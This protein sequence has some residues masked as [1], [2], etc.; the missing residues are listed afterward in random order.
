MLLVKSVTN[1]IFFS[2]IS[3]KINKLIRRREREGRKKVGKGS[4]KEKIRRGKEMNR[5]LMSGCGV[6][7]GHFSPLHILFYLET[8]KENE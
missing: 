3:D 8:K 2:L 7:M 1:A 5:T 4:R 6:K